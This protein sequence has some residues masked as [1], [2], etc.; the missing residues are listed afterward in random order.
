MRQCHLITFSPD[1]YSPVCLR[2]LHLVTLIDLLMRMGSTTD[3]YEYSSQYS[4]ASEYSTI[5]T[6]VYIYLLTH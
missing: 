2:R 4:T 1:I 5:L 3:S 6:Y